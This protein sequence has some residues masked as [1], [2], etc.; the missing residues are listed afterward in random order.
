MSFVHDT[1]VG[2]FDPAT[3]FPNRPLRPER[4]LDPRAVEGLLARY[5]PE[6]ADQVDLMDGYVRARWAPCPR[7][8]RRKVCEFAYRLAEQEG[9]VA[10]ESPLYMICYPSTAAKLQ[11]KA[12]DALLARQREGV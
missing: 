5:C 10:A 6:L 2:H 9:C 12:A 4:P 7:W 1:I 3:L 8:L 11:R